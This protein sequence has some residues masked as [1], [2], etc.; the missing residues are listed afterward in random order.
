MLQI[1]VMVCGRD[2]MGLATGSDEADAGYGN[3]HLTSAV[4]KK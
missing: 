1:Y 4:L 2:M 3:V